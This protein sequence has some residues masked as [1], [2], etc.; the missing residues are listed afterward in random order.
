[1]CMSCHP[2]GGGV[3]PDLHGLYGMTR[4]LA[5]GSTVAADEEYLRES[6]LNPNAKVADGY[7]PMMPSFEGQLSED[8]LKQLIEY[9]KSLNAT[10]N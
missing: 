4:P 9:I 10:G 7:A 1:G 6:I 5:D 3:G 2:A 8:E